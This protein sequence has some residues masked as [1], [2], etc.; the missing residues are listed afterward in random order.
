MRLSVAT[1]AV[2]LTFVPLSCYLQSIF[3]IISTDSCVY[4]VNLHMTGEGNTT[5]R[6]ECTTGKF[7]GDGLR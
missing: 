3:H 6:I 5:R 4:D 7:T 2:L 1:V